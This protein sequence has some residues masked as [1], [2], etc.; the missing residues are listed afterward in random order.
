MKR[1]PLSEVYV[2]PSLRIRL[3]RFLGLQS[4]ESRLLR[5]TQVFYENGEIGH[6]VR[7][8]LYSFRLRFLRILE[9]SEH[10][11][12]APLKLL[13]DQDRGEFLV[14]AC[15]AEDA[16]RNGHLLLPKSNLILGIFHRLQWWLAQRSH[17][18]SIV[19][20]RP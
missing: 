4:D 14:H 13:N 8:S 7:Y 20:F 1:S 18:S 12:Q 5:R 11:E 2:K 9:V 17:R 10:V 3:R 15:S 16:L 6:E 19:L